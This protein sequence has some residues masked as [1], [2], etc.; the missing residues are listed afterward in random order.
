MA[1]TDTAILQ[2][3]LGNTL[4]AGERQAISTDFLSEGLDGLVN[5][6]D[7]DVRDTYPATRNERMEYFLLS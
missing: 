6:T 7:E 3:M 2:Q 1:L 4:A 5:M